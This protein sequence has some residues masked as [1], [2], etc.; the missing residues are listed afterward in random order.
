MVF[1][2]R[3]QLRPLLF[4]WET[5]RRLSIAVSSCLVLSWLVFPGDDDLLVAV[6]ALDCV[7]FFVGGKSAQQ[8]SF[9]MHGASLSVLVWG[10]CPCRVRFTSFFV[11][12]EERPVTYDNSKIV[13][14]PLPAVFGC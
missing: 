9:F 6:S 5:Q 3:D 8:F 2:E 12:L 11:R 1:F 7:L 14:I 4:F 10:R 13:A